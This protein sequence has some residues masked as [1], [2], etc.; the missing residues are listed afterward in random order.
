MAEHI[1]RINYL[2]DLSR[3]A[4]DNFK[5]S[6]EAKQNQFNTSRSA[7]FQ[8]TL[9][10]VETYETFSRTKKWFKEIEINNSSIN[11][12]QLSREIFSRQ[13]KFISS[14]KKAIKIFYDDK[15]LTSAFH[16]RLHGFDRRPFQSRDEVLLA[17]QL[18]LI[19][20]FD[21]YEIKLNEYL[22]DYTRYLQKLETNNDEYSS[23]DYIKLDYGDRND[24]ALNFIYIGLQGSYINISLNEFKKHFLDFK[25]EQRIIFIGSQANLINLFF[26]VENL[27]LEGIKVKNENKFQLIRNHFEFKENCIIP[28]KGLIA[29]QAKMI[30]N[31]RGFK[32]M[33][34]LLKKLMVVNK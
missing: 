13:Y 26:G 7:C 22:V 19:Q 9:L 2:F 1:E 17:M 30:T 27:F 31:P 34:Q 24:D 23:N 25:C 33:E 11:Y 32:A 10:L 20:V 4:Y 3:N 12:N 8:Q 14:F 16:K 21:M 6:V 28:L 18:F 29:Q 5:Y 15:S